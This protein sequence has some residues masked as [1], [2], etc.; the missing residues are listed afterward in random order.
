[1]PIDVTSTDYSGRTKDI[2]IFQGVDPY[3]AATVAPSFGKIS[4]YCTGIQKLIQ[5][6]TISLLT[7]IGSQANYPTFGTD[8]LTKLTTSSFRFNKADLGHIFNF[9]NSKVINEFRAYQRANPGPE[10]EQ[11]ATAVLQD[12]SFSN[13]SL[14]FTVQL[15]PV[16]QPSVNFILPLPIT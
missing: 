5:R 7:N 11:L 6:Y 10:D 4:N 12:I 13:G 15:Y 2:H 9:A 1:M 8:L 14:F 3:G 16:Q